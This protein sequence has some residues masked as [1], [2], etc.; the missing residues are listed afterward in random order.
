MSRE[1]GH[2][3]TCTPPSIHPQRVDNRLIDLFDILFRANVRS[4]DIDWSAYRSKVQTLLNS[5]SKIILTRS[6]EGTKAQMVLDFLD[7]VSYP[8][9]LWLLDGL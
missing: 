6:F 8:R 1:T 2:S 7:Q 4:V 5:P 9:S 3:S